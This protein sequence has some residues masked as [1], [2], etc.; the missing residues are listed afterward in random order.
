MNL[1]FGAECLLP[2]QPPNLGNETETKAFRSSL[3]SMKPRQPPNLGNE[4]E[5]CNGGHS[6]FGP[7]TLANHPISA[8]RLKLLQPRPSQ[9][10][11]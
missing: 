5:T 6:L 2:R 7:S 9:A 4:T 10:H 11:L 1:L 8:T 3:K